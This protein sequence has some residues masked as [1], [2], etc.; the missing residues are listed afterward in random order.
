LM[1]I[2]RWSLRTK[3]AV[4]FSRPYRRCP[5]VFKV[6]IHSIAPQST[7]SAKIKQVIYLY[8]YFCALCFC[9]I[10]T[11]IRNETLQR[12]LHSD[13]AMMCLAVDYE[14]VLNLSSLFNMSDG[15]CIKID[16]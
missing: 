2:Y 7:P 8:I 5:Q 4:I 9:C 12:V 3:K 16:S 15:M 6:S 10:M 1:R 11:Q 14:E 13:A